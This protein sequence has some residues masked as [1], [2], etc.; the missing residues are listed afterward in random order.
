MPWLRRTHKAY[1]RL[2]QDDTRLFTWS[3]TVRRSLTTMPSILKRASVCR[4]RAF[5]RC[6]LYP[7]FFQASAQSF[8]FPFFFYENFSSIFFEP[9]SLNWC[10]FLINALSSSLNGVLRKVSCHCIKHYYLQSYRLHLLINIGNVSKIR[11][12]L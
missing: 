11:Y 12:V 5:S 6:F 4:S 8:P 1:N 7:V 2:E 3:V 9:H 10:K